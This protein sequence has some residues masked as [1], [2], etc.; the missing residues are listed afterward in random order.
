[1]TNIK[2][3]EDEQN[4]DDR[5]AEERV[6]DKRKRTGDQKAGEREGS[7]FTS[8]SEG[9]PTADKFQIVGTASDRTAE[10]ARAR[11]GGSDDESFTSFSEGV[12]A[13]DRFAILD[14]NRKITSGELLTIKDYLETTGCSFLR[15]EAGVE[16]ATLNR[17]MYLLKTVPWRN[18]LLVE[19]SSRPSSR[20]FCFEKDTIVLDNT[21]SDE[22][23][24]LDYAHQCYHATNRL[25]TK[26]Y[27]GEMLDRYTFIDLYIWA[28]VAALITEINVGRDLDIKQAIP[29]V[30]LCQES[31]G[32]L[33][34]INAEEYLQRN[35]M[36]ALHDAL[37]YSLTRG[38]FDRSF[39]T[40]L[41][42]SLYEQYCETFES[43]A[44]DSKPI[45][46]LCLSLGLERDCI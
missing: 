35:G 23:T 10:N 3:T 25:L 22:E 19:L 2:K 26:L 37:I 24:V 39:L 17:L 33:F 4:D 45:I 44:T 43:S 20:E 7:S 31:D 6:Y 12:P 27:Y 8:F 16:S 28:E 32:S 15:K 21:A 41:V 40:L 38:E 30:V 13:A 1:M 42:D 9:L 29:S 34:S 11:K 18:E 46:E 14:Q 36:K 5:L